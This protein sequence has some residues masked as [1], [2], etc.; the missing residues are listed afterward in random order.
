MAPLLFLVAGEPSGDSL[1]AALMS[2]LVEE[3]RGEIGFA[4]VGGPAMARHGLRSLFP[5]SDLAVMGLVEVLPKIP[6]LARRLAATAS[7]VRE[8]RPD[9][10]VTIDSQEFS[11]RLARRLAP[12]PCPVVH[13]VAPTVWAWKPWRARRLACVVDRVL[14]LFPFERPF[15]E[16]V[17]LDAVEVGHPVVETAVRD[18]RR[19]VDRARLLDGAAGPLLAVLPGSRRGEVRRHGPLFRDAVAALARQLPGL[20]VVLPTVENVARELRRQAAGWP[21]PV[22]VVEGGA[23][24]RLAAM[25]ASDAALALSGTVALELAVAGT[26]HVVAFR[27][28][29]VNA[30]IVRRMLKVDR[31][32]P[33]NLVAG[34]DVTPELLQEHCTAPRLARAL[35]RILADDGAAE[36]QRLAMNGVVEALGRGGAAPS[37]RAARAV[38]EMLERRPRR[39]RSPTAGVG[40]GPP[41]LGRRQ[42]TALLD[43]LDGDPVR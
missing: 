13:Y 21:L 8:L 42:G 38:L 36:R 23:G 26:P 24:E 22:R 29:P 5:M 16:A 9:L 33:V 3:R 31:V 10:V 43:Q 6:R 15:W 17:G 41:R 32:S 12:A 37:R 20:A 39:G 27:A 19:A 28:H 18:E 4:G 1:G 14:L 34:R 7:A 11:A 2:A 40:H 25:A 30:A 35:H